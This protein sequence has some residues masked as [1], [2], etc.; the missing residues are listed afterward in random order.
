MVVYGVYAVLVT[1][2]R[3]TGFNH[4]FLCHLVALSEEV[5][6]AAVLAMTPLF[7]NCD[8]RYYIVAYP[9]TNQLVGCSL[10]QRFLVR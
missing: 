7:K 4:H 6:H 10:S 8:V 1:F 2:N 3:I 9:S 5:K